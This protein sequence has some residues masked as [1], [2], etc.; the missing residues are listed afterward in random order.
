MVGGGARV[1]RGELMSAC[2]SLADANFTKV[3]TSRTCTRAPSQQPLNPVS[4]RTRAHNRPPCPNRNALQ[5]THSA[6]TSSSNAQSRTRTS[7]APRSPYRAQLGRMAHSYRRYVQ[8][9]SFWGVYAMAEC[10]CGLTGA[11]GFARRC[12][13]VA[14]YGIDRSLWGGLCGALRSNWPIHCFWVHGSQHPSVYFAD[15]CR[16]STDPMQCFGEAREHARTTES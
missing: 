5:T 15:H 7:T 1:Y 2:R 12:P 4:S 3:S 11:I 6:R 8:L 9:R 14:S 13:P 16:P 10:A